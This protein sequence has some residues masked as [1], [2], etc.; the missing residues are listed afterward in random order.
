ML[1]TYKPYVGIL[2]INSLITFI[3]A[4]MVFR[5]RNAPGRAALTVIMLAAVELSL[6]NALEIAAV[7][8]TAKLFWAKLEYLGNQ[9]GPVFFLIFALQYTSQADWLTSR[10]LILIWLVPV[11][12]M[13]LAA[14]NEFHHLIWTSF[15][16]NPVNP[17]FM[18]YQHGW[19]YWVCTVYAYLVIGGG[20]LALY[21]AA[22]HSPLIF[23][24]QMGVLLVAVLVPAA[25]NVIYLTGR[26]PVAGLDT[27]PL[28]FSLAGLILSIGVLRF[29]VLD[30]I[31]IARDDLIENM[32][33]GV[34]VLDTQNRVVDVNPAMQRL[35]RKSSRKVIGHPVESV[36]GIW[37]QLS[38][39]QR[40]AAELQTEVHSSSDPQCYFELHITPLRDAQKHY[41]GKLVSLRDITQRRQTEAE[42]ARDAEELGVINR[43]SLAIT[44]GL[45]ME[46]VLKTLHEQCSQVAPIDVFYVALFDEANS[47]VHVPLYFEDGKYQAG[48]SRD[49]DEQPGILG[50][51]IKTRKTL[52]L[53][54]TV[55]AIT[56]PLKRQTAELKG[57]IMSYVGIPLTLRERVVGV[58]ALQNHRPQAYSEDQIRLL[59]R[60]AVQAAI[61]IEN[62]RLYAEVQRLAIIDELTGI[63]NYRGL[64]ELGGREVE[65]ARRF[66]RPLSALFFDI[67][68]FRQ[69]NNTYSHATGNVVLQT[70]AERCRTLLRSVDVFARFGGDEFAALLPETTLTEAE[71]VSKRLYEEVA[72][73]KIMTAHGSL[74][75]TISI[76]LTAFKPEIPDLITLLDR[77][78]QGER[79]AK[80]NKQGR[81][82]VR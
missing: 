73:T 31:P 77:A 50:Q 15:A 8:P 30:L 25:G 18:I 80:Q 56:R 14:T 71:D 6:T 79:Q 28:A 48:P 34:L 3:I 40:A 63:Y 16:L 41:L 9:S 13:L 23:R 49:I 45:D 36:L 22:L 4:V 58:M 75:V 32:N 37:S 47:L 24:R 17:A 72:G 1:L 53:H 29:G 68:D 57:P 51:I 26:T 81:V 59:E 43:I 35:I 52:Y 74:S 42:L 33:D 19:W 21:L 64:L 27:A 65:R 69:F 62:A 10:R 12:S 67:D 44:S 78:N 60:I 55:N 5:H 54:D 20:A 7:D 2:L 46:R 82:V 61:A 76:G 39:P 66:N 11:A 38:E 70:V